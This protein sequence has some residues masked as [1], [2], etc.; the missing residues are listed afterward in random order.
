MFCLVLWCYHPFANLMAIDE[1]PAKPA[2]LAALV[3]GS[4]GRSVVLSAFIATA[5]AGTGGLI[6]HFATHPG[7]SSALFLLG[8]VLLFPGMMGSYAIASIFGLV[9]HDISPIF[10]T[11]APAAWVFYFVFFGWLFDPRRKTVK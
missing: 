1:H 3:R 10:W 6:F 4:V 2:R 9:G 8:A 5:I 11:F 7:A